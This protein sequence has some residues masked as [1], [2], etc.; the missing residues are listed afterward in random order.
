[1][2]KYVF[3]AVLIPE[4]S[5]MYSVIFPD[6][7]GCCTQGDDFAEAVYMAGDALAL[8]LTN[9][10]DDGDPIPSPSPVDKVSHRTGEIVTL[11]YADTVR[12]RKLYN[13]KSVT[14][15]VTLPTWLKTM[16]QD[17]DINFSQALQ[18]ALKTKLHISD[19]L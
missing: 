10:E 18:E 7:E 17:A 8:M 4:S 13:S 12:Y 3:P 2:A 15:A 16:A 14:C 6:I 11:V 1:M 19:G 9:L 5:G